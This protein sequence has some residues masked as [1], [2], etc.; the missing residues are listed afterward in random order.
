MCSCLGLDPIK[1]MTEELSNLQVYNMII[2]KPKNQG[3]GIKHT[4][5]LLNIQK[6]EIKYCFEDHPLLG[7]LV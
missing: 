1:N 4:R 2:I 3:K 7:K 5:L 6:D